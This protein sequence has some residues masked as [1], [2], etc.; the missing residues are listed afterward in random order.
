MAAPGLM[1]VL[2]ILGS[3]CATT[4]ATATA[5][6]EKK[7]TVIIGAM[8]FVS[9]QKP[10]VSLH[11]VIEEIH[12]SIGVTAR[13]GGEGLSNL[14]SLSLSDPRRGVVQVPRKYFEKIEL[15]QPESLQ[16]AYKRAEDGKAVAEL[17]VHLDFGKLQ[18]RA[19]LG[20]KL[21]N[22]VDPVSSSFDLYY[23]SAS[24]TFVVE[25]KDACGNRISQ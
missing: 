14:A 5:N 1:M 3:G 6:E 20:C 18:W 2:V 24:R 9:L 8:H 16:L 21:D 13:F 22:P 7:D 12:Q 25:L 11:G 17:W 19:E 23:D 15:F 10:V 4:T